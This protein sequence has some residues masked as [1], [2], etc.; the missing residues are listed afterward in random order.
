MPGRPGEDQIAQESAHAQH[1]HRERHRRHVGDGRDLRARTSKPRSDHARQPGARERD[2][3]RP[4]VEDRHHEYRA[5][6][7][8]G[9]R[10]VQAERKHATGEYRARI[11]HNHGRNRERPPRSPYTYEDESARARRPDDD[12]QEG[13]LLTERAREKGE[14]KQARDGDRDR[15]GHRKHPRG[16]TRCTVGHRRCQIAGR[17]RTRAHWEL[18]PPDTVVTDPERSMTGRDLSVQTR[19]GP[20]GSRRATSHSRPPSFRLLSAS[21]STI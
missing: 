8:H 6:D 7:G 16:T 18:G 4:A 13:R 3:H 15:D 21:H 14:L 10:N 17:F 1:P 11:Y 12:R 2:T 20:G 5:E 19:R 9:H